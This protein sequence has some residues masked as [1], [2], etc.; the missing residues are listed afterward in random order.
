MALPAAAQETFPSKPITLVVPFAAGG[1]TDVIA[2]LLAES[3]GQKLGQ[4]V[5]VENRAGAG[6]IIANKAVIAA[7]AD[8]HTILIG[9]AGTQAAGPAF[10][11]NS[12]FN[13]LLDLAPVAR[14]GS[15][16]NLLVVHPEVP[17]KSIPELVALAKHKPKS[18]SFASSGQGT[19]SHLSALLFGTMA[20]IEMTHVPYR[21]AGPA[22][23][24]LVAGQVQAMFDV[25]ITLLPLVKA[26]KLRV[27]A[28]T[29][30]SRFGALPDVPALREVGFPDYESELWIGIFAPRATPEA[31]VKR[32]S[33]AFLEVLDQ[34]EVGERM[35]QFG[36]ERAA[37]D[38]KALHETLSS[39]H[40]RWR[41]LM[42]ETGV[43]PE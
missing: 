22:N 16:P 24:D 37:G 29:T 35:K 41:R 28:V 5:V 15:T 2:R 43:K 1:G 21:G 12:G 32:I 20:K 8:G 34:N 31:V 7:P 6:G 23:N 14:L 11:P 17:A 26:E 9:T 3:V 36:F 13:P 33:A 10:N 4:N 38:G 25:P 27:L 40:E 42:R 19:V 39:D 30:K 18:L